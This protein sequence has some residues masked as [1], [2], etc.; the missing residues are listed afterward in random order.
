[1]KKMRVCLA[2]FLVLA[3]GILC[4][5]GC[6]DDMDDPSSTQTPTKT[7]EGATTPPAQDHQSG[8]NSGEDND[9]DDDAEDNDKAS[10]T[11][12]QAQADLLAYLNNDSMSAVYV[13][14]VTV[15]G[16]EL[17]FYEFDVRQN[18]GANTS[19]LD[20][21]YVNIPARGAA[22]YNSQKMY[23]MFGLEES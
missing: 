14:T 6:A 22:I 9:R 1:M 7:V 13:K 3:F 17:D 23:E 12:D 18:N 2:A 4:L 15:N 16:G 19:H 5:T 20:Y 8:G 11:V 21:Y 10:Y